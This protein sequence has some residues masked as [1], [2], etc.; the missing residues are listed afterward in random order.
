MRHPDTGLAYLFWLVSFAGINGLHRF[1]LGKPVSGFLYMI[2][3]GFFGIGTIIDGFRMPALVRRARLERRIDQLLDYEEELE[4]GGDR[5]PRQETG[6][7]PG[8]SLIRRHRERRRTLEHAILTHAMEQHG[9][10]MPS[11]IALEADT[12][13]EKAREHLERLVVQGFANPAVSRDG[14]MVYVIPE[15]LDEEGR[16]VL[17][18]L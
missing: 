5:L 18:D 10:V 17:N 12:T 11:R 1:Y 6:P 8:M 3:V 16:R 13:L 7:R 4:R 2:T 14:A 9:I 15:F